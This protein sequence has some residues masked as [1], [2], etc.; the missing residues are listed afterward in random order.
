[1]VKYILFILNYINIKASILLLGGKMSIFGTSPKKEIL[2]QR[3]RQEKILN[4]ESGN[5]LA[6]NKLAQTYAD[7]AE[8]P[9]TK[10]KAQCIKNAVINYEKSVGAGSLEADPYIFLSNHYVQENPASAEEIERK[11]LHRIIIENGKGLEEIRKSEPGERILQ[12]NAKVIQLCERYTKR[13]KD[14][15]FR[16][17]LIPLVGGEINYEHALVFAEVASA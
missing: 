16:K 1:M 8:L 6:L 10:E 14:D 7:E 11:G 17:K 5:Y 4:L 2:N 9:E 3:S 13:T 15:S 12:L